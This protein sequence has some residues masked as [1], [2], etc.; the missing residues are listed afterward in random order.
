MSL[1]KI[2]E[3]ELLKKPKVWLI[4]GVAG[5]IGSN[6]LEKLL[7][8]NQYVIGLDNFS[9]GNQDNLDI[10]LKNVGPIKAGRFRFIQG[11]ICDPRT[12]YEVCKGIDIV[13]HQA[14]LGSIPRSII[15]P[16]STNNANVNGFLNMMI[17]ARDTGVKR[18]VFASSSSVYGDHPGLP[19]REEITGN[20]LSPYAVSKYV[21]ELYANVFKQMYDFKFIGLR[22]FNIFGP[23]QDPQGPYAAVIPRWFDALLKG[24]QVTIYGDG[25]TTRDFCY[26][27]NVVEA[28]ILAGCVEKE[29]AL[30]QVYNI[31]CSKSVSLIELY[32]LIRNE[33]ALIK[34]EIANMEPIYK[35]FRPGDI[36]HSLADI[37]KAKEYLGY[38]PKFSV[39]EG[40][41]ELTK[42]YYNKVIQ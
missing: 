20:L 31:G 27:K 10:V 18:F 12:C 4:T 41:Q 25:S 6:I 36:K 33:L 2:L 5:F 13:L 24:E 29:K 16:V 22:Y 40:I 7:Q 37:S 42:L 28:N 30:G 3:N 8:L 26:I 39:Q 19:K 17:A 32:Y 11:D 23:R 9:T 34:P 38:E 14:A 15:D 35:D 21:N 1:Y